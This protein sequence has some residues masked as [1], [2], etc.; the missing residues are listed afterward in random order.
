MRF[1]TTLKMTSVYSVCGL[2]GGGWPRSLQP[3]PFLKHKCLSFWAKRSEEK[4]RIP[5]CGTSS[6]KAI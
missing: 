2:R 1:F 4:N 5:H 3:P 6:P